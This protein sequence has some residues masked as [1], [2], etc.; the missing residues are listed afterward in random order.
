MTVC[1]AAGRAL[2]NVLP[3]GPS[4]YNAALKTSPPLAQGP[5]VEVTGMTRC[6]PE[7]WDATGGQ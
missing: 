6:E 2:K 4:F 1:W 7:A 5:E 3:L